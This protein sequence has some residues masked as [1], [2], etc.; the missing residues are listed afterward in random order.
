MKKTLILFIAAF[1]LGVGR[2]WGQEEA[3]PTAYE[4]TMPITSEYADSSLYRLN[5]PTSNTYGQVEH[6]GLYP[7]YLGGLYNWDLHE[8]LNVSLGASVFTE[9]G[10]HARR[11]AGFSQN[12]SAIYAVPLTDKLSLSVGG[13]VFNTNWQNNS[14]R[15]AG[16]TASLGYRFDEHWEGFLFVQKN[17]YNNIPAWGGYYSYWPRGGFYNYPFDAGYMGA[18]DRIGAGVRYNFNPSFYI[19]VSFEHDK[20]PRQRF[21]SPD[22]L[23]SIPPPK[24]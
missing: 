16:L 8:G 24:E 12:L 14:T 22:Y 17:L 3:S 5:L 19:E 7:M 18:T 9:F 23:H 10:K 13:Y 6:I 15:T 21:G 20:M 11:G 2:G 1:L 4:D